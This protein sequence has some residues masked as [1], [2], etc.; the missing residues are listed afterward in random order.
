MEFL[1][2]NKPT[3]PET[4]ESPA[5]DEAVQAAPVAEEVPN[6]D[7][8]T[9]AVD[10]KGKK[11]KAHR[12]RKGDISQIADAKNVK[13]V[14]RK[15][16]SF[17]A[18]LTQVQ[19][20]MSTKYASELYDADKKYTMKRLIE[21]YMKDHN[22]YVANMT[23]NEVSEALYV[24]MAEYS[25]LTKWLKRT[26]IEEIN[27][28]SWRDIQ[29]IPAKGKPFKTA[30]HFKSAQHALD[31]IKRLLQ[32][33]KISFDASKPLVTGYLGKNIRV[34]A[35]HTVVV[36]DDIGVTASIRIVNPSK[37]TK[38]QFIAS[39]TCTEQMYNFLSVAY[40]N[41]I[42]QCYAGETG[43]GKTTFMADIMSNYPNNKRLIT[44]EKSV[45]EF[46]L[47]K[48]DENGNA[49]NNVLHFVT[50]ETDDPNRDVTMQKLLTITLTMHPN[51]ICVA[52]MKNE[53][54]WEAQEAAR[55]GHTVLTT[56]HASSIHG[57]YSRLATLCLQKYSEVPYE[58]IISLVAEAFPIGIYLKQLEDG[59]RRLMEIAECVYLGGSEYKT[60]PLYK[61]DITDEI[62]TAEGVK[63]NGRFMKCSPPS[64]ALQKRLRDNGVPASV[65]AEFL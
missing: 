42:S 11:K 33:N 65:L 18:L 17:D 34:T 57:I 16:V 13:E 55:T 51:S 9:A 58:I 14:E 45:R 23:L 43:S 44:I 6:N 41:G 29:I 4:T 5:H 60:I 64:E 40:N 31:V 50:H 63:I 28:N 3:P 2:K 7:M 21:Q 61:Y 26:D 46:D 24:E 54:A 35:T 53:E 15:Y 56:T 52:E 1:K 49:I 8:E 12:K 19:Q 22:Y 38:E 59:S 48:Y 62:R 36:G 39:G 25:I 32:N 37:I 47:I 20:F 27:V 10:D 30:E